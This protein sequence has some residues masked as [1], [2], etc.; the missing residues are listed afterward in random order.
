LTRFGRGFDFDFDFDF[1]DGCIGNLFMFFLFWG[2]MGLGM[3]QKTWQ[4]C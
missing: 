3:A 1:C 2:Q 4:M